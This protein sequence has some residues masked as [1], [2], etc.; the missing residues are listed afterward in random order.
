MY[1]VIY[2]EKEQKCA[3]IESKFSHTCFMEIV[4]SDLKTMI[5]FSTAEIIIT[6]EFSK[7]GC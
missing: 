2:T 1:F 5:L 6:R 7:V 3:N 4:I